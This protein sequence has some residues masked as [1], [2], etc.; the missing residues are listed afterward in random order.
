MLKEKNYHLRNLC[1][2]KI[3][4]RNECKIKTLSDEEKLREFVKK[5]KKK[6]TQTSSNRREM[7]IKRNL[8]HQ[9]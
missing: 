2:E 5:K 7:I 8:E 4:L 1:S 9:E 6:A 3:S